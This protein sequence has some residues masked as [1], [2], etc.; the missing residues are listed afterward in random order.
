MILRRELET[1]DN[2]VVA[3]GIVAQTARSTMVALSIAGPSLGVPA[4]N[5]LSSGS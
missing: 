2:L 5:G 4:P 3:S 1:V